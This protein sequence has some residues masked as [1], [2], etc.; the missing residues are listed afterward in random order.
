MKNL[1]LFLSSLMLLVAG[2]DLPARAA[3]ETTLSA[4]DMAAKEAFARDFATKVL[5]IIQ[6]AK[7]S[8][9][10]R[11]DVLREAFSKSVD[12]DWIA[13]FVLGKAWNDANDEQKKRYA[14]LYRTYLTETYVANFAE[15]PDKRIRD[16]KIFGVS[17]N[18]NDTFTVRTQMMLADAENLNVNYLVRE[19]DGK[20]K[21]LDIAIENVSLITTHRSEFNAIISARGID[22]VIVKLEQLVSHGT[23]SVTL[24]MNLTR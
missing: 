14:A 3:A 20:Y 23:P 16:I 6:D 1:T 9:G 4:P 17:E 10:D 13:R 21:V 15:N 7:K 8:Y 2:A 18:G 11:K 19:Q 22:G 5:A 12:I 24:S